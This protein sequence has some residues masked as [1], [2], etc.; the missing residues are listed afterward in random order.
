MTA[1]NFVHNS[2]NG[3]TDTPHPTHKL[4]YQ[5][6]CFVNGMLGGGAEM[7]TVE[8]ITVENGKQIIIINVL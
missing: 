6:V 4:Q 3:Y 1:V 5:R 2:P 7:M 8:I